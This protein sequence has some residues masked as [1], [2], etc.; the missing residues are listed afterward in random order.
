MFS[1]SII[2]F[3]AKPVATRSLFS[4]IKAAFPKAPCSK[5]GSGCGADG[6]SLPRL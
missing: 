1:L 6:A 5:W 3:L 4:E 2:C